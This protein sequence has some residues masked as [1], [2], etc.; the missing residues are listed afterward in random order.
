MI[1]AH[2]RGLS[3]LIFSELSVLDIFDLKNFVENIYEKNILSLS[4]HYDD[5]SLIRF[6]NWDVKTLMFY[7][8]L[9]SLFLF[10]VM[11]SLTNFYPE[12]E[13]K[14]FGE[15]RKD[16]VDLHDI[17]YGNLLHWKILFTGSS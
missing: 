12:W 1:L 7:T 15:L 14:D 16:W 3:G 8:N 10:Q 5:Q 11:I 4:A 6:S 2:N 17:S 9:F 13:W